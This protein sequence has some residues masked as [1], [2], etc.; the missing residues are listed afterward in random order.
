MQRHLPNHV[1]GALCHGSGR[2]GEMTMNDDAQVVEL[3]SGDRCGPELPSVQS[4]P[5]VLP[6]EQALAFES[7][8]AT[9]QNLHL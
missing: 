1:R 3:I 8:A 5:A 6:W 9:V 7:G 4:T 2:G